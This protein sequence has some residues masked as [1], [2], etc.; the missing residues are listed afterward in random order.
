MWEGPGKEKQKV[1]WGPRRG[2]VGV[3][4]PVGEGHTQFFYIQD[5]NSKDSLLSKHLD[6]RVRPRLMVAQVTDLPRR[7]DERTPG[8]GSTGRGS[9][10]G[11]ALVQVTNG[12]A[13]SLAH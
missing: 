8:A 3:G 12:L 10:L 4:L 1:L 5:T 11:R 2:Q 6:L 9:R 13:S 7:V